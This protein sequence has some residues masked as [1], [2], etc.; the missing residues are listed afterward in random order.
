[1]YK[2]IKSSPNG[3]QKH[4]ESRRARCMRALCKTYTHMGT[5]PHGTVYTSAITAVQCYE[6]RNLSDP[7]KHDTVRG[8]VAIPCEL[9][10]GCSNTIYY[11]DH[12]TRSTVFV[13]L[14]AHSKHAAIGRLY[15]HGPTTE[16]RACFA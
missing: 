6:N 14:Y 10:P 12:V 5:H 7:L 16:S 11:N 1:M 4:R 2:G 9:K 8:L 13:V 15:T 3:L